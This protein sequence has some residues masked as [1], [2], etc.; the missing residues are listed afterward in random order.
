M[1]GLAGGAIIVPV[2]VISW[3]LTEKVGINGVVGFRGS[4]CV[5]NACYKKWQRYCDVRFWQKTFHSSLFCRKLVGY[6]WPWLEQESNFKNQR[7]EIEMEKRDQGSQM[8]MFQK[9]ERESLSLGVEK[10][11]R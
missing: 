8:R 6:S 2:I 11:Y 5:R 1:F 3:R 7:G 4:G 10:K 9:R